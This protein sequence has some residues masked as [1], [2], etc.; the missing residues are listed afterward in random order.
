MDQS[1]AIVY[2]VWYLVCWHCWYQDQ[3]MQCI[4]CYAMSRVSI[5]V[6]VALTQCWILDTYEWNKLR[7]TYVYFNNLFHTLKN[8]EY[9]VVHAM[10]VDDDLEM[11]WM[12]GIYIGLYT[13]ATM[14]EKCENCSW[15]TTDR[16]G[17]IELQRHEKLS[18]MRTNVWSVIPMFASCLTPLSVNWNLCWLLITQTAGETCECYSFN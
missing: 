17:L 15:M 9:I 11:R 7:C 2:W 6:F 1:N 14:E 3:S 13:I 18:L 5:L 12:D 8:L 10:Q 4:E 16:L